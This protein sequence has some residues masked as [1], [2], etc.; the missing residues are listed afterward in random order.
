MEMREHAPIRVRQRY[1]TMFPLPQG[2][3]VAGSRLFVSFRDDPQ[4]FTL[5]LPTSRCDLWAI[6]PNPPWGLAASQ[7][8]VWAVCGYGQNADRHV[9]EFDATGN[10]CSSPTRCP[11]GTGSYIAFDGRELF[12]SQWYEQRVF[13]LT[14]AQVFEPLF[15]A[16][17]GICGIAADHGTLTLLT[18]ADEETLEYHL[19][20]YDLSHPA[21]G[22]V[23]VATVPFRA[24]SL[25]WS[26]SEYLTNHREAGEIVAF[27]MA[28]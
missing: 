16:T 20:R 24:R 27:S 9:V 13:R 2:L 26:G 11:D 1:K 19:E 15:S 21:G 8:R 6:A 10:Q 5:D 4:I 12:L 14:D 7:D 22:C 25:A 18:T 17:R 3:A 23:D 28:S